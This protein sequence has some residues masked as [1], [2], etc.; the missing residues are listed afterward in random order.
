MSIEDELRIR[1]Q[2][3]D[4][5]QEYLDEIVSEYENIKIELFN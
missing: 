3:I 5:V 1:K 2:Q 4:D